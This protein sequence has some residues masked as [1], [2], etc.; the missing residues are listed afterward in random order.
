[1]I[2][3]TVS[4][5]ALVCVASAACNSSTESNPVL[6][7]A[8][9]V[10]PQSVNAVSMFNSCAGHAYPEQNSPNSGKNYFW[11]NSTNF[12][13]TGILK[14]YAACDG[15]AT[16]VSD[17]LDPNEM[18]RGQTLH[19]YCDK[20]STALRYFHVVFAPGLVGQHVSAGDFL[21]YASML[22]TGQTP[23]TTWQ[24]SSNFDIAVS[25]Q[26]DSRTEDY[27]AKLSP[28]ALA[29]WSAR[30]LASVS[31]TINRANPACSTFTSGIGSPDVF[32]FAPVL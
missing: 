4:A 32:S 23:S 11:P 6:L 26:D 5:V 10:D 2:R 1:M 7:T 15:T 13:T 20:S 9:I 3:A 28:A 25:E 14:E 21:G 29:A 27:F 30:G 12:S 17:D 16:Q 22:G 18:D 24:N 19:L 31:Q 8:N